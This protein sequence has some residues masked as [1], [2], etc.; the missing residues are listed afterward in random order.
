MSDSSIPPVTVLLA[1]PDVRGRNVVDIHI[2]RRLHERRMALGLSRAD[3]AQKA[4]VLVQVIQQ[5]EDGI[6]RIT[7][8]GLQQL[9]DLLGVDVS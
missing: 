9:A 1:F 5:H 4:S 6:T 8:K 3:I 2:G 7:A